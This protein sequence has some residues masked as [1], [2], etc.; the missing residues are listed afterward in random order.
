MITEWK[1]WINAYEKLLTIEVS[2][3]CSALIFQYHENK[4]T[5]LDETSHYVD[6]VLVWMIT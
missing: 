2:I 1:Y 6:K 3:A 5:D 4:T